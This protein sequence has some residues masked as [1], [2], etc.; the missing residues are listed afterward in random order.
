M[1]N[2]QRFAA[3]WRVP[4]ISDAQTSLASLRRQRMTI[5]FACPRMTAG[6]SLDWMQGQAFDRG[7]AM[8][9][10]TA[11]AAAGAAPLMEEARRQDLRGFI[12]RRRAALQAHPRGSRQPERRHGAT[13][14]SGHPHSWQA[15]KQLAHSGFEQMLRQAGLPVN[16]GFS[17]P[18]SFTAA[19]QPWAEP[20]AL[21]ACQLAWSGGEWVAQQQPGGARHTLPVWGT[22]QKPPFH[23]ALSTPT[24]ASLPPPTLVFAPQQTHQ[25]PARA[26]WGIEQAKQQ[27]GH[28]QLS[29]LDSDVHVRASWQAADASCQTAS[30]AH[31][32]SEAAT[33]SRDAAQHVPRDGWHS[34]DLEALLLAAEQRDVPSL[35]AR[36]TAPPATQIGGVPVS[37]QH[38]SPAPPSASV[39]VDSCA[40]SATST[41]SAAA[42][43]ALHAATLSSINSGCQLPSSVLHPHAELLAA[44]AET[45]QEHVAAGAAAPGQVQIADPLHLGSALAPSTCPSA[46]PCAAAAAALTRI[47]QL[48]AQLVQQLQRPAGADAAMEAA[49]AGDAVLPTGASAGCMVQA[50]VEQAESFM[51]QAQALLQRLHTAAVAAAGP[52]HAP[53]V[54]ACHDEQPN[55]AEGLLEGA[56]P[57]EVQ[58]ERQWMRQA[59]AVGDLPQQANCLPVWESLQS[60]HNG[61]VNDSN[62]ERPSVPA[63]AQ[64]TQQHQ[65]GQQQRQQPFQP[66]DGWQQPVQLAWPAWAQLE[67]NHPPALNHSSVDASVAAH[68]R[69]WQAGWQLPAQQTL[70][71]PLAQHQ[72]QHAYQQCKVAPAASAYASRQAPPV[73]P[74]ALQPVGYRG[75]NYVQAAHLARVSCSVCVCLPLSVPD[76]SGLC[77]E[78]HSLQHFHLNPPEL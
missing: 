36:D 9:A 14:H 15:I 58:H 78:Q 71:H 70:M 43:P 32:S 37:T 59:S 35:E 18:S 39:Q 29:R 76:P 10:H 51:A 74:V 2:A 21:P 46:D 13:G 8:P 50:V 6:M 11:I 45:Q 49:G 40:A 66:Q 33:C 53:P 65:Q 54:D 41:P 12:D 47:Q 72:H 27:P 63:F 22:A 5:E 1:R 20:H 73:A 60:L 24:D 57:C 19:A 17:R 62:S 23:A 25:A 67:S 31:S 38:N 52:S 3:L 7:W 42:S 30:V 61:P 68:G 64:H 28:Q 26:E 44:G 75:G 48:Q 16:A 77:V 55:K 34:S 4:R 56:A 69:R